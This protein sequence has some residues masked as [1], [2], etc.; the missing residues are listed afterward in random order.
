MD[1]GG[2][3]GRL[4]GLGRKNPVD[5]KRQNFERVKKGVDIWS[6]VNS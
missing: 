3:S 2:G 5:R 4:K 6:K 1:E